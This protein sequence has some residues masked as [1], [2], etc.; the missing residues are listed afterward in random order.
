MHLRE[1]A[2]GLDVDVE[3]RAQQLDARVGDRLPD[4]DLHTRARSANVSSARVT[5]GAALDL[6]PELDERELDAPPS[7]VA[8]SKTS[9]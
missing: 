8:M 3:L 9:N 2:A 1:V 4:E 6:G 5:G 7:W